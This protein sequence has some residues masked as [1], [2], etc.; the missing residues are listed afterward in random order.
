MY[1]NA[2]QIKKRT[3]NES[4]TDSDLFSKPPRK[5]CIIVLGKTE[6]E[7]FYA[8]PNL[9]VKRLNKIRA[10]EAKTGLK[11]L[12]FNQVN[13]APAKIKDKALSDIQTLESELGL[14]LVA[15]N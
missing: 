10:V 6:N 13:A 12:A 4:L 1:L 11:I 9:D 15:V 2:S 7:M 3:L 5:N 8:I 14:T